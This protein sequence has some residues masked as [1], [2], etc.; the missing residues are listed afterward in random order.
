V[1]VPWGTI[2][3]SK[4]QLIFNHTFVSDPNPQLK[5]S[6]R[7]KLSVAS[8]QINSIQR[9]RF[10]SPIFLRLLDLKNIYG[11]VSGLIYL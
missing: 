1:L 8:N 7:I 2:S 5:T 4:G 6:L 11:I 3:Q 10:A 9:P